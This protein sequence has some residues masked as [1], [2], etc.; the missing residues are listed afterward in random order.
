MGNQRR[1]PVRSSNRTKSAAA[2]ARTDAT[3]GSRSNTAA[4][5]GSPPLSDQV[6]P[7]IDDLEHHGVLLRQVIHQAQIGMG[8]LL[9]DS[10]RIIAANPALCRILGR[11][12]S[13]LQDDDWRELFA[14]APV[15]PNGLV[16]QHCMTYQ[17][18]DQSQIWLRYSISALPANTNRSNLLLLQAE[19]ISEHRQASALAQQEHELLYTLLTHIDASIYIKD[20]QGR[21]LYANPAT[22]ANLGVAAQGHPSI[23]GLTDYDLLPLEIAEKLQQFDRQVLEH[24]GPL[25]REERLPK[26]DGSEGIFLSEKLI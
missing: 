19:D 4:D 12:E 2:R 6:H 9:A 25:R 13:V 18:P 5:N 23:L 21:Y 14:I 7:A 15:E 11:S 1:R 22:L 20:R 26:S 16:M 17:R 10:G 8:L 24:G 3:S